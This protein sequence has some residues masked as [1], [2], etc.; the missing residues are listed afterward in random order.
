V[1][2]ENGDLAD[3]YNICI[4]CKNY[5]SQLHNVSNV[6]QIEIH[7]AEPLIPSSSHLEDEIAIPKLKNYRTPSSDELQIKLIKA[8]GEI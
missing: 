7:T 8:G 2:D 4:K 1:K 5:Y 6:R 3:S